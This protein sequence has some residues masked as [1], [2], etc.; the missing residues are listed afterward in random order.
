MKEGRK[1][2]T[3]SVVGILQRIQG[4]LKIRC[5]KL[6]HTLSLQYILI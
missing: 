5:H 6:G 1:K 2:L 3:C 4:S